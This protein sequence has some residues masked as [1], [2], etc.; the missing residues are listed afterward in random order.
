MDKRTHVQIYL[1]F[2]FPW[3]TKKKHQKAFQINM[4]T[5][6]AAS[7]KMTCA[8]VIEQKCE[9][10]LCKLLITWGSDCTQQNSP[11][12][13][14]EAIL[15]PAP[16]TTRLYIRDIIDLTGNLLLAK[17]TQL[18]GNCAWMYISLHAKKI[19]TTQRKGY[20]WIYG[21]KFNIRLSRKVNF[22]S[23]ML[24]ISKDVLP[25]D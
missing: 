7:S 1:F 20:C 5:Y 21:P 10:F 14:S 19:Y 15:E 13:N 23:D 12:L 22:P 18:G 8:V 9:K 25:Y 4:Q 17:N 24:F 16:S 11:K 2:C 6:C 3:K